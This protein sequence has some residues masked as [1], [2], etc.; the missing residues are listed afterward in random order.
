MTID[1]HQN[2]ASVIEARLGQIITTQAV[3]SKDRETKYFIAEFKSN[4]E[5]YAA[6]RFFG[7]IGISDHIQNSK[8]GDRV[9]Q[10]E[11]VIAIE[12]SQ[13]CDWVTEVLIEICNRLLYECKAVSR[14]DAIGPYGP[15]HGST[16]LS[17]FYATNPIFLNEQQM[18]FTI[19]MAKRHICWLI[20]IY[21]SEFK[22]LEKNGWKK[23][24]DL[25]QPKFGSLMRLNR[26][27]YSPPLFKYSDLSI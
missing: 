22:F 5:E 8:K 16:S 18:T 25:L 12:K 11:F 13:N 4:D 20:P 3:Y 10:Q 14:G 7:T 19:D 1:T 24:E 9:V 17:G 23:F 6:L 21:D 2:L 27:N 15:I 26:L